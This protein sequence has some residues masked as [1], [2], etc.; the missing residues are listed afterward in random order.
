MYAV[1]KPEDVKTCYNKTSQWLSKETVKVEQDSRA[2]KADVVVHYNATTQAA[3]H[4][5]HKNAATQS[6][7]E[8]TTQN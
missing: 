7:T 5:L 4:L 1:L 8:P 3:E 6:T 2:I